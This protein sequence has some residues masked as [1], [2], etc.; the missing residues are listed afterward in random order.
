MFG[1]DRR[2]R[3][4]EQVSKHQSGDD[5]VVQRSDDGQEFGQQVDRRRDPH[6]CDDEPRLGATG[7]ARVLD[8]SL[9]EPEEVRQQGCETCTRV[10]SSKDPMAIAQLLL[11]VNGIGPKVLANFFLLRQIPDLE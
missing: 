6:S 2:V 4:L 9:E 8:Q 11:P 5:R 3:R 10:I 7:N 1:D